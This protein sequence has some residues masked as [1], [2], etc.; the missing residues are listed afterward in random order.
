MRSRS[1]SSAQGR[2]AKAAGAAFEAWV[3]GQHEGAKILGVLVHVSHNQPGVR[4]VGGRIIYT[5]RSGTDY[6]GVLSDGRSLAVEAKSTAGRLMRSAIKKKQAEQLDLVAKAGGS[7]WLLVEFRDNE[8]VV[9]RVMV[10]YAA[11]WQLIRWKKLRSAE[12]IGPDDMRPEWR[13]L[14]GECYLKRGV[15]V[16][17]GV[18]GRKHVF[19]RE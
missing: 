3:D 18:G 7:A 1:A 5:E 12:S 2:A 13:I 11:P 4:H 8:A 6:S 10:R 9:G 14:P 19:P 17:V 15:Q 16:P